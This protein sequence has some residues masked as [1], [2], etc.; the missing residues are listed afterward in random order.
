MSEVLHLKFDPPSVSW[1]GTLQTR[2]AN[3]SSPRLRERY[4]TWKSVGLGELALAIATRLAIILRVE[5]RLREYR[6][7]LVHEIEESGR[8]EVHISNGSAYCPH[9]ENIVFEI[10][11][12]VDSCFFEWRSLYDVITKF[13]MTFAKEI[14][15]RDIGRPEI[16]KVVEQAGVPIHWIDRLRR[17][18]NLFIHEKAPWIALEVMNRKPL[19]C[20]IAVMKENLATLDDPKKYVTEAELVETSNRLRHSVVAIRSWLETQV[21]NLEATL[22]GSGG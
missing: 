20:G 13:T 6:L 3:S 1:I 2:L 7:A 22:N 11:S 9:D 10:C 16:D 21:V 12:A 4:K 17:N 14:L 5:V 15:G 8:L 19:E 18:R